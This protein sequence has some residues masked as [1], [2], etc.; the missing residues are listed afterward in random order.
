MAETVTTTNRVFVCNF[1]MWNVYKVSLMYYEENPTAH[2]QLPYREP[3]PPN[4]QAV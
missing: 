2:E 4:P 1:H 3:M